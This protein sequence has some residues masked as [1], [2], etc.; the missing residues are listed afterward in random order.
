MDLKQLVANDYD[1]WTTLQTRWNDMDS[2]GHVNHTA[3][4]SYMETARVDIYCQI[5]FKGINKDTDKSTILAGMEVIYLAQLKHPSSLNIGHR[6]IRVGT[7]SYDLIS[8]VFRQPDNILLC[9]AYFKLVSFNYKKNKTILV[10]NRIK[11]NC[12]PLKSEY[13]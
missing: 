2:L 3:Y 13:E 12:R 10:P 5:G 6:I 7:K 1:F 4:L 11:L 9:S 8:G